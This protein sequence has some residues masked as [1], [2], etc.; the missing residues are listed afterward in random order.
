MT[1]HDDTRLA[2]PL[3][4]PG[5]SDDEDRLLVPY[6]ELRRRHEAEDATDWIWDQLIAPGYLTR[7]DGRP[8]VAGKS[9][10]MFALCQAIRE[11]RSFLG[12]DTRVASVA[13]CS[14]QRWRTLHAKLILPFGAPPYMHLYHDEPLELSALIP[15]LIYETEH[16][17]VELVIL[18]TV[19][20]WMRL[21]PG[22]RFDPDVMGAQM[23]LLED[24]SQNVA[25]VV[26]DYTKKGEAA[27]GEATLGATEQ[28]GRADILV[29]LK[30]PD[31]SL[32][33]VRRLEITGRSDAPEWLDYKMNGDGVLELC[34]VDD[35]RESTD[36]VSLIEYLR[37]SPA[38]SGSKLAR[39][40]GRRKSDVLVEL[41]ELKGQGLVYH[42]G[43]G[44]RQVWG[45]SVPTTTSSV[46][47]TAGTDTPEPLFEDDDDVEW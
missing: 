23:G 37:H 16:L 6:Q 4:E 5:T 9:T 27:Q 46:P 32:S 12:L 43:S 10:L 1:E 26:C 18:D 25:V 3:R 20:K 38:V 35:E 11:G 28:T 14:E 15:R 19:S 13:Y 44:S 7:I 8:K 31:S 24:L 22:G 30:R 47:T 45:A 29:E 40:L 34:D 41:N 36:G 21:A 2:P 42:L 39:E 33:T 17:G